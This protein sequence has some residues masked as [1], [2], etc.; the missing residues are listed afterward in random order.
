MDAFL[1]VFF[2][3]LILVVT[4]AVKQENVFISEG[5]RNDA[6]I[7]Y[8]EFPRG[9]P[10]DLGYAAYQCVV[11]QDWS[12]CR[13]ELYLLF[14][15]GEACVCRWINVTDDALT[16]L[17]LSHLHEKGYSVWLIRR[18]VGLWQAVDSR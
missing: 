14:C 11:L 12:V 17:A 15:V 8:I 3:A 9:V 16:C 5:F 10:G 2:K 1:G 18:T 13:V 6:G 7:S 4:Q